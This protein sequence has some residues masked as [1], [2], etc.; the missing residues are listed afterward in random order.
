MEDHFREHWLPFFARKMGDGITGFYQISQYETL[1]FAWR[2]NVVKGI[3]IDITPGC[4]H[5]SVSVS[6]TQA[7]A[8]GDRLSQLIP[9]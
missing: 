9:S 7:L 5:C 2:G 8:L 4:S 3:A 1:G 6:L